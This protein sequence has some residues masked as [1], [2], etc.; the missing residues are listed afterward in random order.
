VKVDMNLVA[1]VGALVALGVIVGMY[2]W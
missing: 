2:R 1:V